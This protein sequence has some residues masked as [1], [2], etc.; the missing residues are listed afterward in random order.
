[1][2]GK[3]PT[4]S[5]AVKSLLVGQAFLAYGTPRSKRLQTLSTTRPLGQ[6]SPNLSDDALLLPPLA[7][8]LTRLLNPS[9]LY[10]WAADISPERRRPLVKEESLKP[11]V[12]RKVKVGGS[13][14]WGEI[15]SPWT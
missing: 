3:R 5:L 2:T 4:L 9:L 13:E 10:V 11:G 12:G 7:P 15:F 1:M 6:R 8:T 14:L